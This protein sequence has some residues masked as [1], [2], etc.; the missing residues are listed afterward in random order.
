MTGK[1]DVGGLRVIIEI[2]DIRVSAII[3]TD[4]AGFRGGLHK[5]RLLLGD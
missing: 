1:A 2:K 4:V 5:H 3:R